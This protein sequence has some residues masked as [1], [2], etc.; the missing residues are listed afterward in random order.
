MSLPAWSPDQDPSAAGL[1]KTLAAEV[2]ALPVRRRLDPSALA[3][4]ARWPFLAVVAISAAVT[5]GLR[6]AG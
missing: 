3:V 6:L 5:A 1:P 2:L 4:R